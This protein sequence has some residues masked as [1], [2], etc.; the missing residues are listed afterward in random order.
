[1]GNPNYTADNLYSGSG[2]SEVPRARDI[3]QDSLNDCYFVAPMAGLADLQPQRIKD[4][5]SYDPDTGNFTV[6]LYRNNAGTAEPMQISVTQEELN[7]NVLRGGGSTVDNG[8]GNTPMWPAVMETA[9]AKMND[10]NPTD[11][12]NEGYQEIE[13]GHPGDAFFALTGQQGNDIDPSVFSTP[14]GADQAYKEISDALAA[15]QPVVMGS[16]IEST[17]SGEDGLLDRHAYTVESI[18]KDTN[19]EMMVGL[20]NPLGQNNDGEAPDSNSPTV[21]IKL[22]ELTSRNS[23]YGF[24]IGPT[25]DFKVQESGGTTPTFNPT[26]NSPPPSN[27]TTTPQTATP[28]QPTENVSPPSN[29]TATP[30]A[31]TPSHPAVTGEP[32]LDN[33]LKNMRDGTPMREALNSFA[34]SPDG[35][36]FRQEGKA[37]FEQLE[38]AKKLET[39]GTQH[40]QQDNPVIEQPGTRAR[41][42]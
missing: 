33:L 17:G 6:T 41:A 12:L 34:A 25:P 35:V 39:Q 1:M 32:Y 11:N 7:D 30:Q 18:Y 19:G 40:L 3:Q 23:L 38:Q 22:S 16:L 14:E 10:T 5:I 20:R 28:N 29:Q 9:F 31:T 24:S 42:M 36:Q 21:D 8:A 27:Q 26:E 2:P 4:A 37:Q 15:K 13:F